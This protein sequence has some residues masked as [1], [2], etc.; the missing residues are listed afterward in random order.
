MLGIGLVKE[1]HPYDLVQDIDNTTG[2]ANSDKGKERYALYNISVL[3]RLRRYMTPEVLLCHTYNLPISI[4]YFGVL[5]ER[6]RE[7]E[8]EVFEKTIVTIT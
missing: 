5:R 6:E 7:I 2:K 1:M 4:Y 3:T 8:R